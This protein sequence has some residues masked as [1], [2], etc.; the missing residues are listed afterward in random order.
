MALLPTPTASDATGGGA[1]P[2]TRVGHTAQIIDTVLLH[3]SQRWDKY[4]LAIRR[5]ESIRG[6]EAP[7]PTDIGTKGNPRLNAAFSEWMMGWPEGWVTDFINPARRKVEG[8]VSR[9]AAMRMIGNGV[10]PQQ[11]AQALRDLLSD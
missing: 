2:D 10:V 8:T 5:W 1:H 4:E 7:S 3:G 11:A 6:I 9:S